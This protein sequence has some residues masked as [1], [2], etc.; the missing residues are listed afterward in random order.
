[1]Y[2]F[3]RSNSCFVFASS[4]KT[5]PLSTAKSLSVPKPKMAIFFPFNHL[6]YQTQIHNGTIVYIPFSNLVAQRSNII[7]INEARATHIDHTMVLFLYFYSI[8]IASQNIK[9]YAIANQLNSFSASLLFLIFSHISQST[10][11]GTNQRC[12]DKYKYIEKLHPSS[13]Y[14]SSTHWNLYHPFELNALKRSPAH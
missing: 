10:A 5:L 11:T 4:I 2:F 8:R 9:R 7:I 3:T 6:T 1:M 12:T 14:R 13:P